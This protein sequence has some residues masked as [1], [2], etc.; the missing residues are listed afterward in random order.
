MASINFNQFKQGEQSNLTGVTYVDLHLDLRESIRPDNVTATKSIKSNN[1]RI[2][3]DEEAIKNSLI[4]LFNTKP[5][6]RFLVPEFGIR[7]EQ[8]LFEPITELSA[9]TLGRVLLNAIERWEPR[10]TVDN[11]TVDG[12]PDDLEYRIM[13]NLIIP[14]LKI[15]T[16]LTGVFADNGFREITSEV[17]TQNVFG[18]R[19]R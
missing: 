2:S 13:I 12:R 6:Q 14:D 16:T 11:I 15:K 9:G 17:V 1:V 4:N 3:R 7:I 5:G 10:V 19:P 18:P 8:F